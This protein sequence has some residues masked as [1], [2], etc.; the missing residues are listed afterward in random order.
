MSHHLRCITKFI[1]QIILLKIGLNK[2]VKTVTDW[3]LIIMSCSESVCQCI[4]IY[5]IES[6]NDLNPPGFSHDVGG[7]SVCRVFCANSGKTE[8]L[9][10]LAC[11]H[12]LRP[13]SQTDRE[14]ERQT[15]RIYNL[16]R[17]H[18]Q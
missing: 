10:L 14:T 2:Y 1:N 13:A 15:E 18:M 6:Q 12:G 7:M 4:A 8:L 9:N 11:E 17:R 3:Q 16:C 5:F